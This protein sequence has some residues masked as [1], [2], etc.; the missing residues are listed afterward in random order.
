MRSWSDD[1]IF[2]ELGLSLYNMFHKTVL[3]NIQN[4]MY[5]FV[6][7][8]LE[9]SWPNEHIQSTLKIIFII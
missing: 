3:S 5:Y 8:F 9:L 4:L 6:V 2:T 7:C 1:D